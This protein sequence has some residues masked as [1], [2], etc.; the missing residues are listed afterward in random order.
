[1]VLI[2]CWKCGLLLVVAVLVIV[3]GIFV[4]VLVLVWFDCDKIGF[5]D[6]VLDVD[7]LGF[8][9]VLIVLV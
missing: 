5:I 1:V 6:L 8:I 4:V 2:V 7:V 9:C 3:L